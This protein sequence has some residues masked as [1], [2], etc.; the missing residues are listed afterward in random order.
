MTPRKFILTALG[1]T[2][3]ITNNFSKNNVKNNNVDSSQSNNVTINQTVNNFQTNII[4]K[5]FSAYVPSPQAFNYP[6]I[7]VLSQPLTPQ[8]T[9]TSLFKEKRPFFN[10]P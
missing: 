9:Y 8:I 7:E 6:E 2:P 3:I 10:L 4:K 1:F 5:K